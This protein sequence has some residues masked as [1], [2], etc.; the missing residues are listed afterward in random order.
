MDNRMKMYQ[1]VVLSGGTTMFPG[2]PTRLEKE[3]RTLY[4]ERTLKVMQRT[5]QQTNTLALLDPSRHGRRIGMRFLWIR[6]PHAHASC[7]AIG[8]TFRGYEGSLPY[9][10][11]VEQGPANAKHLSVFLITPTAG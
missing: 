9:S 10:A 7:T 8:H 6:R 5:L 1:H 4:L 2:L 11:G 3:L